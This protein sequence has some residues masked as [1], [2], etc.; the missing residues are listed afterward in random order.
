MSMKKIL[1]IIGARP[2][3]IKASAFSQAIAADGALVEIMVHTGQHHDANMSDIFFEELNM[4]QPDYHLDIQGGSHGQMTGRM[5]EKIE[6]ALLKERP[7]MVVV[8]GD[9]NS[10]LAGA[11]AASKLH[12]P[13]AHIEAGLRSFN[14]K[15]PEEVNR[16]LTDRITD[17]LFVPSEVA[18]AH[19]A[20]EGVAA[21]KIIHCGDIMAD[22]CRINRE[23]APASSELRAR[24]SLE[25]KPFLL[26]TIHRQENTDDPARLKA[27]IEAFELLSDEYQILF[28]L[29]P[30][31]AKRFDEMGVNLPASSAFKV[32]HPLGYLDM[33]GL[34][35]DAALMITDSGGVQKEA[36]FVGT[37]CVTYRDETEW[38]EL[39]HEGWNRLVDVARPA[40]FIAKAT[41]AQIGQTGSDKAIYG[42]GHA[43]DI[44]LAGIKDFLR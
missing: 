7:D 20:S 8:Y 26:A 40:S 21:D 1:T 13:I 34:I 19:L 22:V 25:N 4:A 28:P 29:H 11:L 37:P 42:N 32:T 39:V 18:A 27:I 3:F 17:L 41:R 16:I 9:T 6:T 10:T 31:T 44:I 2:Q 12:I 43:A 15:M 5:L 30:R 23:R 36:F 38:V 33:I 24:F 14:M 35:R